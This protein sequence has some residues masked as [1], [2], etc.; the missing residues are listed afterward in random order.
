[1]TTI[2]EKRIFKRIN[3]LKDKDFVITKKRTEKK[4]SELKTIEEEQSALELEQKYDNSFSRAQVQ[5]FKMII[6]RDNL[7]KS[8]IPPI[9]KHRW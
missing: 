7:T 3:F 2:R 6:Q 1:L 4:G 5:K 8:K 9:I